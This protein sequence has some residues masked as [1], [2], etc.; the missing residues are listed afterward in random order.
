MATITKRGLEPAG[1]GGEVVAV[2]V[3]ATSST[4][5]DVHEG[6]SNTSHYDEVWIWATNINT[7]TET[8][9]IQFGGVTAALHNFV[10]TINPNE[11]VLVVPGWVLK[12]AG[13]ELLVKA[14]ATNGDKVNL[15]GYVNRIDQS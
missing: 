2:S 3:D 10:T 5:T 13:T 4:G 8:L 12:G 15:T 1:G 11:T 9:T 14:F 7:S 6:P